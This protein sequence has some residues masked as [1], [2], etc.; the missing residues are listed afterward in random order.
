MKASVIANIYLIYLELID[1]IHDDVE[2]IGNRDKNNNKSGFGVVIWNDTSDN[3]CSSQDLYSKVNTTKRQKDLQYNYYTYNVNN[4]I[5]SNN[6]Y[7]IN[8]LKKE[9]RIKVTKLIGIFTHNKISGFAKF[10]K[11]DGCFFNGELINNT[12]NGFGIFCNS[13]GITYEGDWVNDSQHGFGIE[14]SSDGSYYKGQFDFGL[15][16]G[17][18]EYYWKDGSNYLGDWVANSMQGF[19]VYSSPDGKLYKGE[20]INSSMHGF[21][22]LTI[23]ENEKYYY[24]FF[25]KD[26]KEGL[27]AFIWLKPYFKAYIGFW[28]RSKQHGVGKLISVKIENDKEVFSEKYG[29]W[30]DGERIKWIKTYEEAMSY[31]KSNKQYYGRIMMNNWNNLSFIRNIER[32]N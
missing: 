27:G 10:I 31:I 9:K 29:L 32:D 18:G 28:S 23:T 17:I 7:S 4:T 6:V 12:A 24:G 26:K 19:G 30:K 16:S 22:I 5:N 25:E 13:N 1:E 14:T 21:G 2:Y 8:Q 15:K 20:F 11:K 3:L